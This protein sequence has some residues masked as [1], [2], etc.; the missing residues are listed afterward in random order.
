MKNVLIAVSRTDDAALIRSLAAALGQETE[1]LIT[2]AGSAVADVQDYFAESAGVV[3]AQGHLAYVLKS[4]ST[5]PVVEMTLS[6]QDMALLLKK[7]CALAGSGHPKVAFVGYR[8]MFSDPGLFGELM[9]A[10]ACIR[11]VQT[12]Q[13]LERTLEQLCSDGTDV[14]VGDAYTCALASEAGLKALPMG[15]GAGCLA[16]AVRT[17]ARLSAALIREH[18]RTRAIRSVIQNSSDAIICLSGSGEITFMN[19]QAEKAVGRTAV[20]LRG[21]RFTELEELS[22]SRQLSQALAKA[23]EISMLSL[24]IGQASYM[25]TIV[26]VSLEDRND[27]WII[28]MQ[29][30]AKIDDLDERLRQERRRQGYVAKATFADFPARSPAMAKVLEEAEAYAQ[31][32]VPILLTGEPRLAKSR[33]AEC[34]HNASLRRKNPYVHLDIATIPPEKQFEYLF[35]RGSGGDIGLISQA[36]KGTLFLLDVHEL[37]PECQRQLLSM[38]RTGAFRRV[39]SLDPIPLSV[40]LICSTFMD[41]AELSRQGKWMW[42]LTNTL[43]GLSLRMPSIREMPEDV[44]AYINEYMQRFSAQFKKH[45]TLTDEAMEHLCRYPW[46]GNLG[47]IEYFCMKAIILSDG[48]VVDLAFVQDRLLPDLEAG[49]QQQSMHIVAGREELAVRRALKEAVGSR[50]KAAA[51]LG[52]SRST[53]WRKMRKYGIE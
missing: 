43:M 24:Q 34:I 6:G 10:E 47:G 29:E 27:G 41:L 49:E 13:E 50:E 16:A 4:G 7:A 48:P 9:G 18:R 44:P 46:P 40:R 37:V 23:N 31:Y 11:H 45:V 32:D 38:L 25:A 51:A 5:I 33:F 17:A 42:Q 36:H 15:V 22:A 20:Q 19:P 26:P 21:V 2:D 35:G 28:T 1:V 12:D 8:S 14:V 53:L 3:V 39:N 52:L 30:F